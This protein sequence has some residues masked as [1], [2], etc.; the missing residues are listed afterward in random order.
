MIS[1]RQLTWSNGGEWMSKGFRAFRQDFSSWLIFIVCHLGTILFVSMIPFVGSIVN[2]IVPSIIKGIGMRFI[3]DR[4]RSDIPMR[5]GAI[6]PELTKTGTE[7]FG[8]GAINWGLNFVATLP[9][10]VAGIGSV[11]AAGLGGALMSTV[12]GEFSSM[13]T[14]MDEGALVLVMVCIFIGLVITLVLLVGVFMGTVF[15]PYLIVLRGVKTIEAIKLSFSAV[16]KNPWSI[17][18]L[19]LYWLLYVFGGLLMCGVGVLLIGPIIQ[20][21]IYFAAEDIFEASLELSEGK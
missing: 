2:G 13:P 10:L 3:D 16:L 14:S 15:A 12:S 11:L 6:Q 19:S 21:S 7:L 20:L 8:L 4:H 9:V 17:T 1:I 5:F 18:A